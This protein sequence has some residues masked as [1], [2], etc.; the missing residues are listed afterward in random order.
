METRGV[1]VHVSGMDKIDNMIYL[2]GVVGQFRIY[3]GICYNE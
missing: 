1:P 2:A 3:W